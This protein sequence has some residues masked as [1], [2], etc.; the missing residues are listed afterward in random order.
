MPPEQS[1]PY[2]PVLS[3][4]GWTDNRVHYSEGTESKRLMIERWNMKLVSA[5]E[6]R[7]F[8]SEI[9]VGENSERLEYYTHNFETSYLYGLGHCFPNLVFGRNAHSCYGYNEISW[10]YLV[11][12]FF[13]RTAKKDF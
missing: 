6:G 3:M 11:I 4:N 9:Y 1:V 8:Q 2:I 7:G 10:G 5:Y 13:K 12:D